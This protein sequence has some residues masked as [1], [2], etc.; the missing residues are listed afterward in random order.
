MLELYELG[1]SVCCQEVR[2]VLCEKGLT[3]QSQQIDLFHHQQYDP[4]YLKLD[5]KGVVPTLVHDGRP[6][7]E[8]T[9]ICEYLDEVLPKAS[10]DSGRR[11]RPR[12]HAPVEQGG[13]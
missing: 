3:W 1:D 10:P 8:S 4:A 7:I 11:V 6:V 12:A 2:Q 13:R 9:L 5:L